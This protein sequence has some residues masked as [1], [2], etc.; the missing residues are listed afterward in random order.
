M[1]RQTRLSR[2]EDMP[3]F[4]PGSS[5]ARL[6]L[7]HVAYVCVILLLTFGISSMSYLLMT[8]TKS[9]D[10]LALKHEQALVNEGLKHRLALMARHQTFLAVND[11]TVK[12][13]LE[14][15]VNTNYGSE[16]AQQMWLD[17][18][19]DWTII[20]GSDD[21]ALLVAAED[22]VVPA[23]AGAETIA[24]ASD[25]IADARAGYFRTRRPTSDG[26]RLRYI[27]KGEL[28]PIYA[29]DVREMNGHP[30]LVS[31]M[32]IIP[33]TNALSLPDT[34]P[35]VLL[36]VRYIETQFL[37]SV[38][39]TLLLHDFRYSP[40]AIKGLAN[41][42]VEANGS[43]P[44]GYFE[45]QS[46]TPGT[47]IRNA[48][49]PVT[50]LLILALILLGYGSGRK[51]AAKSK[52]LEESEARNRFMALHDQLTGLGNRAYFG[53]ALDLA[54]QQLDKRPFAV[55][56]ID[57]DRFK[58]VND[59]F[60]HDAG[61]MV[62]RQVARSMND[63]IGDDGIVART[64]GDEFL[65]LI[66]STDEES[67]LKWLCDSL[68]EA[69]SKPIPVGGGVAHIGASIGCAVAPRHADSAAM[70]LRLADQSLYHAKENG[71]SMTVFVDDL[72]ANLHPEDA[73]T[74]PAGKV[75]KLGKKQPKFG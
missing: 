73:D 9:A 33:E 6:R 64:G 62:I 13:V 14:N 24:G 37:A 2:D 21:T 26:F 59:T 39:E 52:A 56:A 22:E 7:R 63:I 71:R 38:G 67:R 11:Q 35:A 68:I 31:A 65:A 30:A 55:L 43:P 46:S 60:G 20:I 54:L 16:I 72:F 5:S 15:T 61:D 41:V 45:W 23:S 69:I 25:L 4:S 75:S 29:S 74:K 42:P 66:T 27:E 18:D 17:F 34:A 58:Q 50:G 10:E 32:S 57:L 70:V 8:T 53:D 40:G 47:V 3:A 49:G 48:V 44:V 12:E 36:S 1:Y 28:A 51:L 19:H